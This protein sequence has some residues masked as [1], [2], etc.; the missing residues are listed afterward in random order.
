MKHDLS[1]LAPVFLSS[2]SFVCITKFPSLDNT[3][4]FLNKQLCRGTTLVSNINTIEVCSHFS[5][6][7][8]GLSHTSMDFPYSHDPRSLAF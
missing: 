3:I 2:V 8:N 4:V 1:L 5:H 6:Q 7:D